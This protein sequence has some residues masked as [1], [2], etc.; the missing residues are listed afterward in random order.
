MIDW[1][2]SIA[3]MSTSME[4]SAS[5]EASGFIW[6]MNGQSVDGGADGGD[7]AGGDQQEI[8][9]GDAGPDLM[10]LDMLGS[11]RRR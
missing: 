2:G 6:S 9:A 4:A 3:E 11:G 7:G 8:A 1:P 10:R 5:A